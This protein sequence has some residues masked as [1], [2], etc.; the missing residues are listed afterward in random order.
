MCV[1]RTYRLSTSKI[2]MGAKGFVRPL[3]CADPNLKDKEGFTPLHMC[4][5]RIMGGAKTWTTLIACGA[6]KN[7]TGGQ[8]GVEP[9]HPYMY[10]VVRF[11]QW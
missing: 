9:Q 8:W 4:T 10:T 5:Y 11:M 1:R 6:D 3:G 7:I 2:P